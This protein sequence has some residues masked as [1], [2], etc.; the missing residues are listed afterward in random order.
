MS[1][2]W[3]RFKQF[4]VQQDACA[5]KVTTD[6]CIQGAWAPAPPTAST[7]LDIGTGTGLLSLMLAQRFPQLHIDAIDTDTA[8]AKQAAT[9]AATSP[10]TDRIRVMH[11][12]VRQYSPTKNYDLIICNP[13]FFKSSLL[14]G[15]KEKDMARHD[16]S[17]KQEELLITVST[18]LSTHG[19]FSLLLPFTEYRQWQPLFA[20]YGLHEQQILYVKHHPDANVKRVVSILSKIATSAIVENT[21]TIKESDGNYTALFKNLLGNFYLDL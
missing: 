14:S 18:L 9:N 7:A 8:A 2:S 16:V 17:L 1:N 5:M 3:F 20:E 11:A 19:T 4:T 15:N 21:L 12:D 6:A 10:W 13:P